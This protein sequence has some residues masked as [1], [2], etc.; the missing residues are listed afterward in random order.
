MLPW[1]LPSFKHDTKIIQDLSSFTKCYRA[2]SSLP[3]FTF[4]ICLKKTSKL[5]PSFINVY[6]AQKVIVI[7]FYL[8]F[9]S[10]HQDLPS[11]KK[12]SPTKFKTFAML[13]LRK[14]TTKFW[15]LPSFTIFW[16]GFYQALPTYKDA[17]TEFFFHQALPPKTKFQTNSTKFFQASQ[18][19]TK[20][21]QQTNAHEAR[22]KKLP[23][24]TKLHQVLPSFTKFYQVLPSFTK[25]YQVLPSF[26]KFY[27]VLLSFT[28]FHQVL[29]SFTKFYQVLPSLPSLPS[30]TK[31]YQ[32]SPSFN[33]FYQV[34][35]S[36]TKFHQ[37]L[38][39]FTKFIFSK[40]K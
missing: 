5:I 23:S 27:Q 12:Q 8:S 25:F 32:V 2:L 16:T 14:N 39:S 36:F 28:K 4:T 30:F 9:G 34:L 6:Q 1:A 7:V 37:V 20:F 3:F 13:F 29:P 40:K 18:V 19:L 21:Y 11:L 24:F 33:K 10:N 22:R 35:P 31:F 15:V 17:R 38:P 26:T